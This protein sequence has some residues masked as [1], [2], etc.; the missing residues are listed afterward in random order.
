[1]RGRDMGVG[2]GKVVSEGCPGASVLDHWLETA[3]GDDFQRGLR[4]PLLAM[5]AEHDSAGARIV[6]VVLLLL[7]VT[8]NAAMPENR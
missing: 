2:W 8:E 3:G 4:K 7:R 1:M 6:F 5:R